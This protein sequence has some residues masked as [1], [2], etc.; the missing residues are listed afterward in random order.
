LNRESGKL[1]ENKKLNFQIKP[2]FNPGALKGVG[3]LIPQEKLYGRSD[4]AK[5]NRDNF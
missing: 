3:D 5:S 2:D 1:R 4:P